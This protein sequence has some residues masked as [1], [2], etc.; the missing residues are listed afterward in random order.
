[1]HEIFS[2]L[3][4]ALT[5]LG[6]KPILVIPLL[7]GEIRVDWM[8]ILMSWLVMTIIIVIALFLRRSLRQ[9]VEEKPTR[10]QATLDALID[11][12]QRQLSSNFSSAVDPLP[13]RFDI[14]LD[15]HRPLPDIAYPGFERHVRA[16]AVG[17]LP[18][19]L[20]RGEKERDSPLSTG[21]R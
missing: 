13:L 8:T 12:L 15:R 9:P 2:Q 11:L 17:L 19:A 18:L 14:Q 16:S 10:V 6:E 7:G 20:A 1:M 5:H 3:A 4:G 21:V